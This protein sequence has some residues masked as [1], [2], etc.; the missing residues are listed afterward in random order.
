MKH[1][2]IRSML[3]MMKKCS[4]FVVLVSIVLMFLYS[5][6]ESGKTTF[7][8]EYTEISKTTIDSLDVYVTDA[9]GK[10][11]LTGNLNL[12]DGQCELLMINPALDTVWLKVF[13]PDTDVTFNEVFDRNQGHW[14][15]KY[16]LT[17]YDDLVPFG[18]YE[19]ELTYEN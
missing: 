15:F 9:G 5:C 18:N 8:V 7:K 2:P 13:E 14:L 11:N 17:E 19:F 4:G 12:I 1:I 16:S 3:L 10:L 6:D